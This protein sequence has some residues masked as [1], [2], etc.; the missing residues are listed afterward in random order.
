VGELYV[1]CAC[2]VLAMDSVVATT[3]IVRMKR[4]VLS[5]AHF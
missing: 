2:A 3:A 5:S 1:N 4:M